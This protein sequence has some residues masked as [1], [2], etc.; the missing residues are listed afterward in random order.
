MRSRE[1]GIGSEQWTDITGWEGVYAISDKGRVWVHQRTIRRVHT[2]PYTVPGKI[3]SPFKGNQYGHLA[4]IL[5]RG[6]HRE[7]RYLH[8]LVAEHFLPPNP[9]KPFVLHGPRGVRCNNVTNL[10]RGTQ[11]DNERDKQRWRGNL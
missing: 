11:S 6:Q 1:G 7:K 3:V 5:Y 9:D 4:V 10:R 8:H 2:A